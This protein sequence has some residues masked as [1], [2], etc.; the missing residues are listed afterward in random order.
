MVRCMQNKNPN[1]QARGFEN[2]KDVAVIER[3]DQ[4]MIWAEEQWS[5]INLP[6]RSGTGDPHFT[7]SDTFGCSA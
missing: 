4:D 5:T 7:A 6:I 1:V 2:C 3:S